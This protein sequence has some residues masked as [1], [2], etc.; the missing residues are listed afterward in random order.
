MKGYVQVYTGDGKGKTTA[1]LGLCVRAVG[2]G[3]RVLFVQFLKR[4]EFSEIKGLRYL[5]GSVEVAQFGSG[6]FV[7]GRPGDADRELASAAIDYARKLMETGKYGV[8]ILDE[9]N[10]ALNMGIVG[11]RDVLD[12]IENRP[13]DV[14]LVLTGRYAPQEIM[15][16]ADLVTE[17]RMVK[18]YF[19]KG[20]TA[21]E[22]IEK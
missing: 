15:D 8:V 21:R 17:C 14:E 10:V 11:L 19:K 16:A 1:S 22:G 6:H 4:G 9:V 13:G 12:L 5:G 20:V 3:K 7:R 2:A 18:H